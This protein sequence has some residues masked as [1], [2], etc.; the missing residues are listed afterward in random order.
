[1]SVACWRSPLSAV[2]VDAAEA[3]SARFAAS[4]PPAGVSGHSGGVAPDALAQCRA[5]KAVLAVAAPGDCP[6]GRIC[7]RAARLGPPPETVVAKRQE[8]GYELLNA[9]PWAH[10]ESLN[11]SLQLSGS[12]ADSA[13]FY[14][15]SPRHCERLG[16]EQREWQATHGFGSPWPG[17]GGLIPAQAPRFPI[18]GWAMPPFR[19]VYC[20]WGLLPPAFTA[21]GYI[22][23]LNKKNTLE[24]GQA[25]VNFIADAELAAILDAV[26]DAGLGLVYHRATTGLFASERAGFAGDAE[27]SDFAALR[28]R[29]EARFGPRAALLG[30]AEQRLLLL[31]ELIA[32][33]AD[34][35]AAAAAVGAEAAAAAAARYPFSPNAVQLAALADARGYVAVQGG[36]SYLSLLWGPGRRVLLLQKKG[37]EV[38]ADA[39]RWFPE[40]SGMDVESVEDGEKLVELVR[41]ETW[42][43][44]A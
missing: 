18:A 27:S 7:V 15:A 37:N 42:A 33:L 11:G 44:G 8:L 3:L 10:F 17:G 16:G 25:P 32:A 2:G 22:F 26:A 4:V 24:W 13:P 9:V 29:A 28:A 19:A 23:V 5:A 31:P 38:T 34:A 1:M 6:A 36:P 35:E 41:G 21:R 40:L 12:M 14:T 20:G 43:S 39:A 30:A